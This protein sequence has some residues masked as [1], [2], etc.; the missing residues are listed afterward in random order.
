MVVMAHDFEKEQIR[1]TKKSDSNEFDEFVGYLEKVKSDEIT[2]E[3]RQRCIGLLGRRLQ[4][5]T[6]RPA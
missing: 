2:R 4:D 5:Q 6:G 1:T 3:L